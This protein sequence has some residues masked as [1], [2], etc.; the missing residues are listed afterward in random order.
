MMDWLV[1]VLARQ[2]A[3]AVAAV[4]AIVA[5]V[6]V[7]AADRSVVRSFVGRQSWIGKGTESNCP[8]SHEKQ[9]KTTAGSA[10]NSIAQTPAS[11]RQQNPV[12]AV[13]VAV[14]RGTAAGSGVVVVV[15][16]GAVV[17]P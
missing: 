5:A 17:G 12:A 16:A 13:V 14:V 15:V 6:V 2:P 7:V 4:A 10:S 9:T 8:R 11:C 1:V 3:T